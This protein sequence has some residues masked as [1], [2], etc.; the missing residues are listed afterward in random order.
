MNAQL[1]VRCPECGRVFDLYDSEQAGEWH[2]GH[3]CEV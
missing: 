3:D 1:N 2:S